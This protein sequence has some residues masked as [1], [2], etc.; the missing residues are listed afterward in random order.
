MPITGDLNKEKCIGHSF[1]NVTMY[2]TQIDNVTMYHTQIVTQIVGKSF[3]NRF[4]L[5]K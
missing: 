5:H 2:H 4:S 3:L 1:N